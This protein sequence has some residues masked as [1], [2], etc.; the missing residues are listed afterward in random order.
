L[1]K[2]DTQCIK[3]FRDPV[4]TGRMETSSMATW[5]DCY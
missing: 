5:F 2:F 3:L 4:K 1:Q